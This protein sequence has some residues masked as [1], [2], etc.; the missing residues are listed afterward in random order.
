MLVHRVVVTRGAG[1]ACRQY[2]GDGIGSLILASGVKGK[3]HYDG[4]HIRPFVVGDVDPDGPYVHVLD[5]ATLDIMLAELDTVSDFS[6]Y[7]ASKETFVRSGN[8]LGVEGEEDLLA[9]YA[10]RTDEDGQHAFMP[11]VGASWDDIDSFS[12][13]GD[14]YAEFISNPQYERRRKANE[15]S[16]VWDGL[17]KAFT[18][19]LLG[20]TSIVLEG[21]D[22]DLKK[23]EHA[24]RYMAL[25][26]RVSRRSFGQGI[27]DALGRGQEKDRFFRAMLPPAVDGAN[28]TGYFFLTVRCQEFMKDN[29]GCDRY[30]HFRTYNLKLYGEAMLMNNPHLDRVVGIAMEPVDSKVSSEDIGLLIQKEWT[31]EERQVHVEECKQFGIMQDLYRTEYHTTEFEPSPKRQ[32][33]SKPKAAYVGNRKERRKAKASA[34]KRGKLRT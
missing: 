4:D 17:I 22:F 2:F 21:Y 6:R 23:S 14:G 7:L 32:K 11:P 15:V 30:R 3:A 12:I 29:G 18:K 5:D 20:G 13:P 34:R 24:V 16:Y 9:Y 31:E 26:D 19:H 28:K 27:L 8:L 25:E 10:V 1:A 33:A